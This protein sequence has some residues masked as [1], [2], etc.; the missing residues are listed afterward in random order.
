VL[1]EISGKFREILR[2]ARKIL[3]IE[4]FGA[5]FHQS[6]GVSCKAR[7]NKVSEPRRAADWD[8]W[9]CRKSLQHKDLA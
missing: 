5:D 1:P 6:G 4:V 8:A 2:I 9:D 7:K 3:I